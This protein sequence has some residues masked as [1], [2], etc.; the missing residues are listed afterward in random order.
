[1]R[2][3]LPTT[4]PGPPLARLLALALALTA[5]TMG[6]AAAGPTP[7]A[8]PPS[9]TAATANPAPA[10]APGGTVTTAAPA[11]V[12]VDLFAP[13]RP[14]RPKSPA[15]GEPSRIL[16]PEQRIPLRFSHAAHLQRG[17]QCQGCHPQ[18]LTSTSARDNLLPRE[19]ACQSCHPIDHREPWKKTEGPPAACAACHPGAPPAPTAALTGPGPQL[20][21]A[22][23]RVELPEPQLKFNHQLHAQRQ[24]GCPRCHGD[25]TQVELATRAQLPRMELCLGCH[26]DGLVSARQGR[27]AG[28]SG[29]G[30]TARCAACHLTAPDGTMQVRFAG[31]LLVPSGTL[32]G[33]DHGLTFRQDHRSVALG[34]G[35]YCASC[36]RR[37]WCQRCHNGIVKPLDYHGG[38]F[39][40]RHGL[41]ARRN[42][43]DCA[44][45][46]RQQTFCLGCHE[47]LGVVDHA[48]LPG[49]PPLSG[50][51]P[52]TARRFHPD[53]WSSPSAGP[54]HHAYEAQRNLRTCTSCHREESCLQCHSA[55]SGGPLGISANPHPASWTTGGRCQSLAARNPRVCLKCHRAG[56]LELRCGG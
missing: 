16:F 4:R 51:A 55:L 18:A 20:E 52:V 31:G 21:D 6:S 10:T 19:A 17:A 27:G 5:L 37:D 47:R 46:H 24:I 22:I 3:P 12:P 25:L 53:G 48:S 15:G 7:T 44:S 45:C 29:R 38:D 33:D 32:R 56:S 50:F 13:A 14:P 34:D 54:G 41:E 35:D 36:H 30:A 40:S 9:G 49:R 8:A 11:A 42:Q 26:N 23:A 43:L 1:M 39:V 28:G 2:P